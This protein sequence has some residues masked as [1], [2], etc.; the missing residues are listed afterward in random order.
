MAS[1]INTNKD[2]VGEGPEERARRAQENI[3]LIE[4]CQKRGVKLDEAA[5]YVGDPYWE[6]CFKSSAEASM[7]LNMERDIIVA[8]TFNR[9]RQANGLDVA[10]SLDYTKTEY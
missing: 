1:P 8:L 7:F 4:E 2:I 9:Y 6:Y 5:Y 3:K 10:A